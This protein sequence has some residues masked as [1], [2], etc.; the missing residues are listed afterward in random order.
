[1]QDLEV[2]MGGEKDR[3]RFEAVSGGAA[4]IGEREGTKSRPTGAEKEVIR[5]RKVLALSAPMLV[6]NVQRLVGG[7]SDGAHRTG[8]TWLT[9]RLGQ[10]VS[11]PDI[12]ASAGVLVDPNACLVACNATV[13]ISGN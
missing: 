12:R 4:E 11:M 6:L 2:G 13:F 3:S 5:C 9:S 10:L 1:M 7:Q 8:M